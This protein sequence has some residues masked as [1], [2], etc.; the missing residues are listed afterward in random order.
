M[1]ITQLAP[2]EV[3]VFGSNPAGL[4]AAGAAA[5][6]HEKFGAIWGRSS[7]TRARTWCCRNVSP[8]NSGAEGLGPPAQ[9]STSSMKALSWASVAALC[10]RASVSAGEYSR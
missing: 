4:H 7:P 9:L 8:R 1:R 6:A 10:G 2:G 3:F 5:L